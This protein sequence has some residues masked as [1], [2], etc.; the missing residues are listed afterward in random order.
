MRLQGGDCDPSQEADPLPSLVEKNSHSIPSA[1][2]SAEPHHSDA[3]M[4]RLQHDEPMTWIFAGDSNFC[5][6]PQS[7]ET[8]PRLVADWTK[9]EFGRQADIYVNATYA[10]ARLEHVRH[11]MQIRFTRFEPDVV[12]LVCGFADCARGVEKCDEFEQSLIGIIKDI[13]KIGAMPVV[14]TP[15]CSEADEETDEHIDHLIFVE[16]IRGCVAEHSA[17]LIDHWR[18][19][20]NQS[21]IENLWNRE[22]QQPTAAGIL[23][24]RTLFLHEMG[25]ERCVTET[26][27]IKKTAAETVKITE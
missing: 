5:S 27:T 9:S 12:T 11:R 7:S 2:D 26:E 17:I 22:H 13:Q 14:C 23:Q 15:P 16:A 3:L 8:F 6:T 19:W 21:D 1:F 24:M 25:I 10:N 4:K 18:F 20:E